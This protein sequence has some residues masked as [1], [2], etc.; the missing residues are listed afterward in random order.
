MPRIDRTGMTARFLRLAFRINMEQLKFAQIDQPPPAA[1]AH[2]RRAGRRR[3]PGRRRR[4]RAHRRPA[5]VAVGQTF[6]FAIPTI[7]TQTFLSASLL[8]QL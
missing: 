4:R 3:P 1:A 6:P 8:P 7:V 5:P 2:P